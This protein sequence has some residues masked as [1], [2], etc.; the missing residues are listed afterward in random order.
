MQI[1]NKDITM[2]NHKI[3]CL[4]A[5]NL[6]TQLILALQRN[7]Q[8]IYQIYSRSKESAQTLA[9]LCKTDYTTNLHTIKQD[10]DIYIYALKDSILSE[11]IPLIKTKQGIHVH[12]SGSIPITV[13]EEYQENYGVFYPFQT[14]SKSRQVDFTKIPILIEA[15]T[16]SNTLFLDDFA[17]NLSQQLIRCSSEQ[18]KAVHLSGVFA[19]NFTNHMY[20]IAAK[21]L[22]EV[23][24]PFDVLIPLIDEIGRAHV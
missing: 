11:V 1:N 18:R 13:F 23:N 7:K 16:E 12:T 15:N 9:N 21:L 20:T 5:G 6:A 24:M 14:F 4:G 3:V 19:C 2:K 10:A 17:K 22:K 8:E